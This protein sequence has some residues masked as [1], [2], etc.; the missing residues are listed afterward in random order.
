MLINATSAG[1]N[2]GIT[3]MDLA[4]SQKCPGYKNFGFVQCQLIKY[5]NVAGPGRRQK[6]LVQLG[7]SSEFVFKEKEIKYELCNC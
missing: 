5:E 1:L 7:F 2:A 3:S 4:G 6:L